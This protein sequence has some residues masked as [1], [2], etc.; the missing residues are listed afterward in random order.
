MFVCLFCSGEQNVPFVLYLC[1]YLSSSTPRT[2]W[3]FVFVFVWEMVVS[4]PTQINDTYR[5]QTL[6]P[7]SLRTPQKRPFRKGTKQR[8]RERERGS[9]CGETDTLSNKTAIVRKRKI[10]KRAITLPHHEYIDVRSGGEGWVG[11]VYVCVCDF[12]VSIILYPNRSCS[13]DPSISGESETQK[14]PRLFF[15]FL[16]LLCCMC[17]GSLFS[18]LL[19][20]LTC[21]S[22]Y[23]FY[24]ATTQKPTC[25]TVVGVSSIERRKTLLWTI[26]P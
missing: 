21:D 9:D 19:G 25:E 16:S 24:Y 7:S 1:V 26:P 17:G 11:C 12:C 5:Q 18:V 13:R 14:E 2:W 20:N 4:T 22:A 6:T 15:C 3:C 10:K 23:I 8:M